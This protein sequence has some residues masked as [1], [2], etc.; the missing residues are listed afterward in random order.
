[1]A[2]SPSISVIVPV[3]K[4]EPYLEKCLQSIADQ[5]F[6][7][8][9]VLC[10]N[11]S[12]PDGSG[13]ILDAWA[14]RDPRFVHIRH[15]RNLGLGGAR[16]TAIRK[17]KAD[18]LAS[19]D[20]DDWIEP[21][22]LERVWEGREGGKHDIVCF[23]FRRVDNEG[24]VITT[25]GYPPHQKQI[26]TTK[27]IFKVFNPAFW[28]K[29]WRK[30]LYIENDIFF[31]NEIY[32]QDLA[33]TPRV[34]TKA[35]SI[36]FL[37][38]ILYNY[39]VRDDSATFSFDAKHYVDYIKVFD[40]IHDF[41]KT[42]GMWD[43]HRSSFFSDVVTQSLRFH[44]E[45]LMQSSAQE[46]QKSDY[47]RHLLLL[48]EAYVDVNHD[49]AKLP[50]SDLI[51]LIGQ[52]TRI[53]PLADTPA[54]SVLK[55]SLMIKSFLRPA[56]LERLL[57]S[58]GEAQELQDFIF[59][60]IVIGDDSPKIDKSIIHAAIRRAQ[61]IHQNL[62]VRFIDLGENVGAS[63]GRNTIVQNCKNSTILLFDDDF[64][65]DSE[66]NIRAALADFEG[67]KLQIMGG[68]LKN[69]YN[70]ETNDWEYWG[71]VGQI[72]ENDLAKIYLLDERPQRGLVRSDYLLQF[73]L[74]RRDV[75]LNYNWAPELA[76]EEHPEF[77][78]RLKK[79][80]ISMGLSEKLF[81][82]H[83]GDRRENP[84]RYNEFRFGKEHW[85]RF[86]FQSIKLSGKKIRRMYRWRETE[87][88][89]WEANVEAGTTKQ[90]TLPLRPP[91][92]DQKVGVTRLTPRFRNF[93]FGY[94]DLQAIS[95]DGR[96][97]L[98]Q[99]VP[100]LHDIPD[101]IENSEVYA[102]DRWNGNVIK[103]IGQSRAWCHQQTSHLQFVPGTSSQV[104]YNDFD[105][106]SGQYI[107]V[108][109]NLATGKSR[110]LPAPVAALSPT[111][112]QAASINFSRLFDYRP[113]YGYSNIPDP[114]A[115]EAQP[116]FDGLHMIDL[117]TGEVELALSYRDIA[118]T[119]DP[120]GEYSERKWIINHV[121]YAPDGTKVFMLV[122]IFSDTAPYPT[123]S[124]IFDF[125]KNRLER[126]FGFG[127]HYHWKDNRTIA[128]S[129]SHKMEHAEVSRSFGVF[130]V[131]TETKEA[132]RL[133]PHQF[134]ND[135]HCS[136]SPDRSLLL[137]DSY[138]DSSFPY[139]ALYVYDL[140]EDRLATL[141]YFWSDPRLTGD[142]VDT[143][144]D[145]HPRWSPDGKTIS[146]DS[147]HEGFRAVYE[148]SVEDVRRV[149]SAGITSMQA[150]DWAAWYRERFAREPT[151]SAQN[152]GQHDVGATIR[153]SPEARATIL[154]NISMP[155]RL[156][157][158]GRLMN[159]LRAVGLDR[160]A[161]KLYKRVFLRTNQSI[162]TIVGIQEDEYR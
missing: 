10:V 80:G 1:M 101:S 118:A 60:E 46:E 87:F 93:S 65:F 11:D 145:L 22:L 19:V 141:G 135:G 20:S 49:L 96:Y 53:R 64:V 115:D 45:N 114:F 3:Y 30:G 149:L 40:I 143:R 110:T 68:W 106:N 33:T 24:N 89:Q 148:I 136:Y 76:T 124:A 83:T 102:I 28:N 97:T 84:A 140:E 36:N 128:I 94:Y 100:I 73:F 155:D 78:Y 32:G 43:E 9:E 147:T 156:P 103:K 59:D 70:F 137:Y 152:E 159:V 4:T 16:N 23:G 56:A 67:S 153:L 104:I 58:I 63:I 62:R 154:R 113:G 38:D 120:E 52:D 61:Y 50:T 79:S 144:C 125:T 48:R 131:N 26:D 13:P 39:L 130:E 98:A 142:S 162:A 44:A 86:L 42:E 5:T 57:K 150:N 85:E 109:F 2:S 161:I 12:S 7:D 51:H 82:K 121:Q 27:N 37:D 77:F 146:F 119:L 74:A 105:P 151:V 112:V 21:D 6:S 122:R 139:R 81:V 15:E 160:I 107:S 88:R 138:C 127:S 35:R 158:N 129:G 133:P 134:K 25:H 99:T 157:P 66:C 31:P 111:G 55:I 108:L 14:A 92:L 95:T 117:N 71:V 90:K 116:E 41:L 47:L 29:L 17:A 34:L 69:K 91:V 54:E 18:W 75:L 126:I 123:Y 72:I 132:Y 8:F